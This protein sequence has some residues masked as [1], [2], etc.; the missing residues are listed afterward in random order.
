MTLV[1]QHVAE[2]AQRTRRPR[3]SPRE[4]SPRRWS[5]VRRKAAS[6]QTPA[7]SATRSAR[8]TVRARG[9]VYCDPRFPVRCSSLRCPSLTSDHVNHREHHHPDRIHKMPVQRKHLRR[10]RRVPASPARPTRT[11]SRSTGQQTDDHVKRMQPDQR[12][13]R[14]AEKIRLDRQPSVVNQVM[15]LACPCR[16]EKSRRAAN[17]SNHHSPANAPHLSLCAAR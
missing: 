3:E 9:P 8:A 16:P 10:A 15:P 6:R 5:P 7:R 4:R 14:R 2:P 17:V 1:R 11:P 13:I 12:I